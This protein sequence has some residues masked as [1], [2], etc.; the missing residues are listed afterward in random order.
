MAMRSLVLA[1]FCGIILTCTAANATRSSNARCMIASAGAGV[2]CVKRYTRAVAECRTA[3][4][5]TCEAALRETGELA[6]LLAATEPPVR[7]GCTAAAADV[8]TSSLG[9][10]ELVVRTAEACRRWSEDFLDLTSAD[11]PSGLSADELRCQRTVERHAANLRDEVVR[12]YGRR[13]YFPEFDGRS[14]ARERRDRRVAAARAAARR[15][16]VKRCGPAFDELELVSSA[17]GAL[18]DDRVDALLGTILER[19]R[20]LAQ[21]LYPPL[22]LGPT[23]SFGPHSVGVR[24]LDLDDPSRPNP[25]GPGSRPLRTEVFNPSTPAATAGVGRDVL[26]LFGIPL[27]PVPAHRD[28]A[29]AP[30]VFPLIVYSHGGGGVRFESALKLAHLASHGFVVVSADDPGTDILNPYGDLVAPFENHAID[31][32]FLIDQFLAFAVE[33]GHFLEGA[34]DAAR[35]GGMGWSFGGYAITALASGPFFRGTF[36]DPRLKAIMPLDGAVGA[37]HFGADAPDLFA[38]IVVPSL[39]LGGD[40]LAS[41]DLAADH[42]AMFEALQPGPSV[43]A[44]GV[45]RDAGHGTF[46]DICDVPAEV[47]EALAGGPVLDCGPQA[48]AWRY[49]RHII[50][51]LAV[52]FF[53]ATLNGNVEALARLAPATLAEIEDLRWQAK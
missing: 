20:H 53:D 23:A 32:G 13:C 26:Q 16:I 36:T 52:N 6:G 39:S 22:N 51:Y 44:F 9:L 2:R 45:L 12:S 37:L 33:P 5:A 38:T 14:C 8:L 46:P 42:E 28:V 7:S 29:R 49:A 4:D 40:I 27:L 17:A 21:R 1:L 30:G 15:S 48:I 18:L 11:D 43:V 47:L 34:V 3:D 50:A 31:V 10:D 24:T 19:A 41:V 25:V 35:I